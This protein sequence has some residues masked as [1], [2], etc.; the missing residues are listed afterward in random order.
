M[1]LWHNRIMTFEPLAGFPMVS[2]MAREIITRYDTYHHEGQYRRSEVHCMFKYTLA[3]EG[4]FRDANGEHFTRQGQ[5]FLCYIGDPE[6]A[7][8]YPVG[9]KEDWHF[10]YITVEAQSV[11][12]MTASLVRKYGPVYNVDMKSE[13]ISAM[14][15]GECRGYRT[16]T[17]SMSR[18]SELAMLLLHTLAATAEKPAD[19]GTD[20]SLSSQAIKL[21][22]DNLHRN[23][24]VSE[25]ADMLGVSREHLS[26]EFQRQTM[27]SPLQYIRR[28]KIMLACRTI[29]ETTLPMKQIAARLGYDST[30]HFYRTF[31]S[32]MKMT[33]R[34]F[35][36][37]GVVPR[38]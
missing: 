4:V 6:T 10:V 12:E 33:P 16:T 19:T 26:R 17:L 18:S 22:D 20:T 8:Y 31:K 14:L 25:L 35:R 38:N 23:I 29:K 32:V 11:R 13:L 5:G 36:E 9:G 7:Y 27:A 15:A 34:E 21:I 28:Q 3:G 37:V 30:E 2:T 1:I 24:N